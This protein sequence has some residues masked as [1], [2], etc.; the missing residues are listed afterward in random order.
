MLILVIAASLQSRQIGGI[1][2]SRG[3]VALTCGYDHLGEILTSDLR[4]ESLV[5]LAALRPLITR[6][7]ALKN[8]WR[9]SRLRDVGPDSFQ[10]MENLT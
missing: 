10:V 4:R 8:D 1:V 6:I 2:E 7:S 3:D 9:V 5:H